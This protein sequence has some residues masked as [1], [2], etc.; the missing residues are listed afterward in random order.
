VTQDIISPTGAGGLKDIGRDFPIKGRMVYLNNASIGPMSNGVI[1]AVNDFLLDVR[2]NGR[3]HYPEWCRIADT[4]IKPTIARLIGADPSEIAFVKNT[5]E[6]LNI[7][8]NG[9]EWRDGDTVVIADI[10]YPSNV[11]P[12]MNLKRR[13]V[14]IKWV[15]TKNGRVPPDAVRAAVDGRTRLVSLSAV[16]FSNGFRLDLPKIS[17]ICRER[18]VLFNLDAIQWVGALPL[19]VSEVRIDFLSAGGHKWLLGPIGTGFFYCRRGSLER[20]HPA[21]V[22]YHSVD[23]AE[24]HMDYDLTFRASAGRFE[25]ALVN[26]PGIWGLN[27]AVS[28]LADLGPPAI[29][30]HISRLVDAAVEGLCVKGY[31]ILSPMGQGER[32]GILSFRHPVMPADILRDRL[33]SAD[34]HLSVRGGGLRVSPGIYNDEDD[35]HAMLEHLP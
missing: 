24:D 28:T 5:T 7:V 22:G 13:G 3:N 29:E 12:W 8:A 30:E 34:I 26:F 1:S 9:L 10:E 17:D 25:E 19:N 23:K 11:Y 4:E 15:K 32:S 27:R 2:D 20:L 35:I 16:Q 33:S 14:S 21:V 18:G 6:G 31:T